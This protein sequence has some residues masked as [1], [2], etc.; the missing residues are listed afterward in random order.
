MD[1]D[2]QDALIEALHPLVER[3][4]RERIEQALKQIAPRKQ[5]RPKGPT[6]YLEGDKVMMLA[7]SDEYLRMRVRFHRDPAGRHPKPSTYRALKFVAEEA[8]AD[9]EHPERRGYAAPTP[10]AIVAR[11]RTRFEGK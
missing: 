9:P 8:W 5:G 10:K 7:A 1:D 3:Y 4:G 2:D 11:L 6:K